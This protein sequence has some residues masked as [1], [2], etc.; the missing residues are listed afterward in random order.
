[1]DN[2]DG[3]SLLAMSFD[4]TLQ[5]LNSFLQASSAHSHCRHLVPLP[6]AVGGLHPGRGQLPPQRLVLLLQERRPQGDLV[7]LEPPRLPRAPR[8]LV[9]LDALL[10]VALVLLVRGNVVLKGKFWLNNLF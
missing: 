10:P 4:A 3:G 1:M 7:L 2:F 9:V 8:G 5:L 6:G